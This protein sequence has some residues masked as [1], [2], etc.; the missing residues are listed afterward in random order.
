MEGGQIL[1][2]HQ[3][4]FNP[5][6]PSLF[7]LLLFFLLIPPQAGLAGSVGSSSSSSSTT[8]QSPA[9]K[10]KVSAP[11]P[12]YRESKNT[13]RL[14]DLKPDKSVLELVWCY[15]TGKLLLPTP[16]KRA[17]SGGTSSLCSRRE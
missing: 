13:D 15:F 14:P 5:L 4:S 3:S 7:P 17:D 9:L 12:V 8:S 6:S 16:P 1:T 2:S 11:F 10:E